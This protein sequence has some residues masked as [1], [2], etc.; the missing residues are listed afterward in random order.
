[1]S[2]A[3]RKNIASEVAE[4]YFRERNKRLKEQ[5]DLIRQQQWLHDQNAP[6]APVDEVIQDNNAIEEDDYEYY[7]GDNFR[8][9]F[10]AV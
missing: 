7:F 4:A 3:W 5:Q 8:T 6:N 9:A 10:D 1:M 2:K